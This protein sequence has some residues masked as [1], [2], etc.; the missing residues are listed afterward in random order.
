MDEATSA[1]DSQS[2]YLIQQAM[3]VLMK[4]KTVIVIAHRLS[5]IMQMDTI[6]VM[7]QGSIVEKGSHRALLDNPHGVYTKLWTIQSGGFIG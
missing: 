7:E 6:F 2:E 3:E 5:T 1:L 4:D